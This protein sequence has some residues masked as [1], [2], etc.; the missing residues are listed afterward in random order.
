MGH[1]GFNGFAHL[2]GV[3][4]LWRCAKRP[5]FLDDRPGPFRRDYKKGQEL[6]INFFDTA[7]AYQSGTSEQYVGQALRDFAKQ[8]DVAVATKFCRAHR[9]KYSRALPADSILNG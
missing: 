4:G 8:E 5:A 1:F 2:Y 9:R 3:H 7:I 6:G